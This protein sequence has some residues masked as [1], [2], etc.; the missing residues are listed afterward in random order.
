M[1]ERPPT[2]SV[3][4]ELRRHITPPVR[5]FTSHTDRSTVTVARSTDDRPAVSPPCGCTFDILRCPKK[6]TGQPLVS[7]PNVKTRLESAEV[8]SRQLNRLCTA[9][10]YCS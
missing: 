2:S 7:A 8:N 3:D 6:A 10:P 1:N 9:R 4:D 5:V